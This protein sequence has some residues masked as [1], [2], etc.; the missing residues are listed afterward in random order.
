MKMSNNVMDE[1]EELKEY[2]RK[3]SPP[4]LFFLLMFLT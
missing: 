4:S 1:L 2:V 3:N